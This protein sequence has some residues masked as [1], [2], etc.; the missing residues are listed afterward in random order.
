MPKLPFHC[1]CGLSARWTTESIMNVPFLV[2][3]K[4]GGTLPKAVAEH[5]ITKREIRG[6][7]KKPKYPST[8][9]EIVKDVWEKKYGNRR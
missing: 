3:K 8:I 1:K 6:M 4:C 5:T 2:C 9:E 7:Q